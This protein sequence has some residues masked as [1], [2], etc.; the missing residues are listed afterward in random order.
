M[1]ECNKCGYLLGD[2]VSVCPAC[3]QKYVE[4]AEKGGSS[5]VAVAPKE[6]QS[7]FIKGAELIDDSALY[8][9]GICKLKGIGMRKDEDEAF[10]IFRILAFRGHTDGMYKLAEMYLNQSPPNEEVARNWLKIACEY[11]HKQSEIMLKMLGGGSSVVRAPKR[12]KDEDEEDFGGGDSFEDRVQEALGCILSINSVC[13]ISGH[14]VSSNGAGFIIDG[15]YV[16]TNAHVVGE[17]WKSISARFDPSIDTREYQ[18][19]PVK[20]YH[21]YDI[22]VLKFKG[23]ANERFAERRNLEIRSEGVKLGEE[24]YTIGNPLVLG[25]SLSKGVISSPERQYKYKS[26][27]KVIQTDI[28]I[29]HGN[30]GGALLDRNNNVLGVMTFVPGSSEGGIGMAVPSEYIEKVLD[31]IDEGE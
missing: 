28:T 13:T 8:N 29:N 19:T 26:V 31:K 30:S 16:I 7:I 6:G 22:A 17:K 15:G 12:E 21:K 20:V 4:R 5:V 10:E 24:V 23:Y 2:D 3:G 11:G 14:L 18:L 27:E 25:L 1:K 9:A